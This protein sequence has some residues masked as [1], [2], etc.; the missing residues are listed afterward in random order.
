[1]KFTGRKRWIVGLVG[2]TLLA[3]LGTLA[4]VAASGG[5]SEGDDLLAEAG[6]TVEE[7]KAAAQIVRPGVVAEIE[8]EREHGKLVFEVLIGG[9]EVIVDADNGEV[10][11]FENE[12]GDD[13]EDDSEHETDDDDEAG[14]EDEKDDD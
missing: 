7:A 8:L 5:L 11:G 12:T 14:G 1:M 6:I 3:S 13:D 2:V 10:L 9:Q 4:T